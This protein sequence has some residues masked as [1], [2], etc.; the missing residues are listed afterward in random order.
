MDNFD[1]NSYKSEDTN[2]KQSEIKNEIVTGS[3]QNNECCNNE[4]Y[5]NTNYGENV[6]DSSEGIDESHYGHL[7]SSLSYTENYTKPKAKKRRIL[8]QMITVSLIS[9]ILGGVT[10]GSYF[11]FIAPAIQSSAK[12]VIGNKLL[13]S[14]TTGT[15]QDN[16][17]TFKK[18]VIE[19]SDSA[20]S[21][22]AEKVGPSVVGI[23]STVSTRNMFGLQ[24]GGGEG[25]GIIYKSDGYIVTNFHVIQDAVD[26]TSKKIA[27][28][29]KIEVTLPNQKDKPYAAQVVGYDLKTDLAVIKIQA[30]NLP[31]AELGNSGD[32]KVGEMAV[33]IGNPGGLEYMG[34]VT[35][36]VISG[37]NRTI[38]SENGSQLKLIQ[39]DAAINPGNSGG[40]LVNSKGQVIG[41]NSVKIV[42]QGYEGL[43]FA[44]PANTVKDI[45]N[46]LI[47]Y[48]YVKG[49]AYLGISIDQRFNEQIA[50]QYNVPAGVLVQDVT[51]ISGAYK[52]GIQAGD[53]I[54]KFG[55]QAV[56]SYDDL[57][58]LKNKFKPGDVVSVE[59]YRDGKSVSLQVK[60]TEDQN[61]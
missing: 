6:Y 8:F 26:T 19:S 7:K 44:I 28:G 40:A 32:L 9:S 41:I 31:V 38:E 60:L 37:L 48:K 51:P 15:S 16:S 1:F 39:T 52:A 59:I 33:A 2:S 30:S 13:G 57:D 29:A 34:S 4:S 3:D 10:V 45:A 18:V 47:D 24:Q 5:N 36:G 58:N 61:N 21:A 23:K 17:D 11:Q 53:I 43:G 55:G 56:K 54:T 49:R 46:N 42:A 14:A 35:I 12:G 20:V 50:Q 25:S 22:I 27:N